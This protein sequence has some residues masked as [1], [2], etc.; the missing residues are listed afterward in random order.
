M[1]ILYI[2]FFG[3]CGCVSRYLFSGWVYHW[4]GRGLPWGTL[5]VNVLGSFLLGFLMEWGLRST[6]LSPEVRMGIATGFMGGFTTFSTFSYETVRLL[7]EGS[8]LQAGANVLLN[9]VVCAVCAML[10][11][12]LARQI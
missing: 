8:L 3:A 11:I 6:M 10:G 12:Y 5:A 7:E 9:V 1:Q 2:A 4:L